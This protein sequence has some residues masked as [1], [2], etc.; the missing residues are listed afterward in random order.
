MKGWVI[1]LMAVLVFSAT[2]VVPGADFDGDGND[3]VCCVRP[4]G[5]HLV[6]YVEGM[7]RFTYGDIGD[8]PSAGDH[9][10]DGT[11][12]AW[13]YRPSNGIFYFN[14]TPRTYRRYGNDGD[15]PIMDGGAGSF[16]RRS[17]AVCFNAGAA[18]S[19]LKLFCANADPSNNSGLEIGTTTSVATIWNYENCGMYIATNNTAK[20]TITAAGDVGI[21]TTTPDGKLHVEGD[22]DD[23]G[24]VVKGGHGGSAPYNDSVQFFNGDGSQQFWFSS[25]GNAGAKGDWGDFSGF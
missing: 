16:T 19:K 5:T 10:G 7:P 3:D 11:D 14:T 23:V 21:G 15:F 17:N 4:E 25:A 18:N 13:L 8:I 6:W 9:D 24:L 20:M 12:E 1:C 2:P 22:N